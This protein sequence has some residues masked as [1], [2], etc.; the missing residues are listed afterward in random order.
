MFSQ[1]SSKDKL[2]KGDSAKDK[3]EAEQRDFMPFAYFGKQF[4]FEKSEQKTIT[5]CRDWVAKNFAK[6]PMLSERYINKL[7][8]I[9]ERGGKTDSG[10]YYDLDL[11]VKILQIFKLDDYSSELRVIDDSNQIWFCQIL[12]NK[13]RSL[14][15]GHFVRIRAVTLE[16]HQRYAE[17]RSFGLKNH[18]NI[19]TLPFP[20][21]LA[22]QMKFD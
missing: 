3:K 11:Q 21:F 6:Y 14:R 16:H 12:N 13:Y 20:C 8:D 7:K 2:K 22:Q 18:S 1:G 15:E 10:R 17:G 19:M 9:P 4:S 5:Q